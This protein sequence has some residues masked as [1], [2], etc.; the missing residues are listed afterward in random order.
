MPVIKKLPGSVVLKPAANPAAEQEQERSATDE[1]GAVRLCSRHGCGRVFRP[2]RSFQKYCSDRCRGIAEKRR[3]SKYKHSVE[4][5]VECALPGCKK[6]FAT[7]D[8]KRRFCS[9]EHQLE[10]QAQRRKD[11][12]ERI[13]FREECRKH[14]KTTHWLKRY[15]S[16]ECRKLERKK[17]G[18]YEA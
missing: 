9:P 3:P 18:E 12:E 5:E 2:Y 13:C 1:F 11:P 16:A 17:R 10:A 14:F 6:K 7:N 15:C 4:H 8:G